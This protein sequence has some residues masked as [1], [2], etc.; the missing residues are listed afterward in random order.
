MSINCAF[1]AYGDLLRH[2]N[3]WLIALLLLLFVI[4]CSGCGGGGSTGSGGGNNPPPPSFSLS[5]SN[6]SLYISAANPGSTIVSLSGS[7]GFNS[8]VSI[9]LQNLPSGVTASPSTANLLP[10]Q[11]QQFTLTASASAS[12]STSSVSVAG[13]S[14]G[15]SQQSY[16]YL[17]VVADTANV[18]LTRTRYVRT[19]AVLP[20]M[21]LFDAANNRFFMSDPGS[22]QIF[23][24]DASTRQPIG[25]IVVPGAYG[26]DETPDHTILYT[27]TQIGDVYAVDPVNMVVTHR[28]IAS[29]IGPKGYQAYVV[30]VMANGELALLGGGGGIPSIDGYSSFAFWNPATNSMQ[31]GT[32]IG[33]CASEG[34]IFAFAATGDRTLLVLEN[35]NLGGATASELCTVDPATEQTN[36]IPI[37]GL[38]VTPTPDGKS[39]LV[40][41]YGIASQIEVFNPRTLAQTGTIQAGDFPAGSY[42]MVSPDSSTVYLAPELGGNIYAYNISTGTQ[43]GW[44]PDIYTQPVGTWITASDNTGLL[45]GVNVE[46]IGFLDAGAMQTG[47]VGAVYLGGFIAP[48]TG[49]VAGGTSVD[50]YFSASNNLA[51]V[52]FGQNPTVAITAGAPL[53]ATTPP[54]SP[55]PSDVVVLL[56]D[57]GA[58]FLPEAFSYGPTILEVTPNTSTAEGGGTGVIF[59]YGFGS[60]SPSN[61]IPQGL[62]V[63][64]GGQTVPITAF[65][66]FGYS[67]G[68][69]PTPLESISYTI[70]AGTSGSTVA[71]SVTTP[72]GTATL[73]QGMKYLPATHS[74][75]LNGSASLA[76]G[77]YD[78]TRDAYYFTDASEI[79]VY[80]RT[81]G[82]WLTSIQVPTAPAGTSHRLWG[83]GLSPNGN[84]LAVADASAG[85][86][87][88]V[89]PSSPTSVQS[90]VFN[91]TYVA[92]NQVPSADTNPAAL[93]V[94]DAGEVYIASFTTGG[95]GFDA[96]FKLDTSS[97]HVTDYEIVDCA[98]APLYKL[99]ISSDNS[100][101]FLN[102]GGIVA[103]INTATD[104]V[105]SASA[106]PGGCYGDY[107]LT[108]SSGQTTL[109]ASSYLY[110]ENLNA[111]SYLVLNDREA[112]NVT[113][114]YGTQL[115][116]DGMLLF[117]PS[118]SG[119]DVY[120]GLLGTLLS[121]IALPFSLSQ[122]YDALVGDGQ[123]NTLIAITGDNGSGI[124]VV[125]L[126]SLPD[127]PYLSAKARRLMRTNTQHP[128][129]RNASVPFRQETTPGPHT[130]PKFR[131]PHLAN[132]IFKAS[133]SADSNFML[134][135]RKAA[136][137]VK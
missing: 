54:G 131:V 4:A 113:Y 135:P 16:I 134:T 14:G 56:G 60:V 71:V 35:E 99:A 43:V 32:Q 89:D 112:S 36:S 48:N 28:Y 34:G 91:Q 8:S 23:V 65:N 39:I 130:V 74:I 73:S 123:D 88:L 58:D 30:H 125:D 29:Q 75:S 26:M 100:L 47:P 10:G 106:D 59:G 52:Y 70:P 103:S 114:V 63:S 81:L 55:G 121:R 49:P 76:Q 27:G 45:A 9:S 40:L 136:S 108:L 118:T 22:N 51:A 90:F 69:P 31:T 129:N 80:S 42:M 126:S 110:D 20:Y 111:G 50:T 133:A 95:T 6:S 105:T 3:R 41:E 72:S 137:P 68:S 102:D 17:D 67:Y 97:G 124:A 119:I 79:R 1:G 116:P 82:Q 13:I 120:D 128:L 19:D 12:G 57:G 18:A 93:V 46:G 64:V 104:T 2:R 53:Y 117:Q 77:L 33:R 86:I 15:E 84:N 7:N 5:L 87:Y 61:P 78:P 101:V 38:P 85:M 24:L 109:E 25:S 98:M 83:I 66:P 44:I 92:G 107:D 96:F 21:V 122:N 115:S 132:R 94:S 62:Q 11:S 37:T 127:L